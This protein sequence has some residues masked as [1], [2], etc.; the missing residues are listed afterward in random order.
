[1]DAILTVGND[2]KIMDKEEFLESPFFL[3][4]PIEPFPTVTLA[5]KTV[6]KFDLYDVLE[7]IGQ[8]DVY[9]C[10]ESDV[11]MDLKDQPETLAFLKLVEEVFECRATYWEGEQ[12]EIDMLPEDKNGI[13]N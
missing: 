7:Y 2:I 12:I 1:M 3:D 9:D 11:Y 5:E 6:Q 4:Y 10:W 13:S 8:G